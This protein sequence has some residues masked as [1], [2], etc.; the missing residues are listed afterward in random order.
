[1]YTFTAVQY[2]LGLC[3]KTRFRYFRDKATLSRTLLLYIYTDIV[4]KV[5]YL[6][7]NNIMFWNQ[8]ITIVSK[9]LNY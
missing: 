4:S 8:L 6:V 1:M 5:K 7:S 3:L 9:I 2:G